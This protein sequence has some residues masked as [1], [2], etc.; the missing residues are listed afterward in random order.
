MRFVCPVAERNLLPCFSVR[1]SF[2]EA[3][4]INLPYSYETY[5]HYLRLFEARHKLRAAQPSTQHFSRVATHSTVRGGSQI[6]TLFWTSFWVLQVYPLILLT[7]A[8]VS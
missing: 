3:T 1:F 5:Q 2:E 8:V 4:G 7:I 6:Y